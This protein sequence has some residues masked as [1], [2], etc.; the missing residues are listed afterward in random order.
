MSNNIISQQMSIQNIQMGQ[1][2]PVSNK[3]DSSIHMAM[4]GP[5][6]TDASSQQ[7]PVSSH[8][9]QPYG[10]MPSDH[11][12]QKLSVSNLQTGQMGQHSYNLVGGMET[13]FNTVGQQSSVLSKRKVPMDSSMDSHGLQKLVSNKRVA[14]AENRPWLHQSS[15][16]ATSNASSSP[17]PQT[18][19]TSN[20][21]GS[22][23]P[24]AQVKRSGSTK[25]GPQH[26]SG[27]K[28]QSG[29]PSPKYQNESSESVRSKLRESL[30]AALALVCEEQDKSSNVD[31]QSQNTGTQGNSQTSGPATGSV[32]NH[33]SEGNN[34]SLPNKG[35]GTSTEDRSGQ[36]SRIDGE[37]RQSIF[38]SLD[39]S[40]SVS[41]GLFI[42]DELLQGNGLSWVLESNMLDEKWEAQTVEKQP[43]MED[44]CIVGG[45]QYTQPPE[46]LASKIEAELYKLYGGVNKKYKEKGRSLL[47]NLK[48]R[49]NPELREKVMSGDIAPD[50]LC[51]M[52][53]E[54]LASKEL[55]E[56]R[57][58][59][60][61]E[62]A[63]M[64]VLPDSGD[65]RRLVKKTHKGEFQVEVEPEDNISAEVAI[66]ASSLT[67][68]RPKPKEKDDSSASRPD[69]KKNRGEKS[70]SENQNVIM[71]PSSD[72]SDFMQGLMV[73]ELK[74]AEFLPPIVSL[75]EFMESLNAEDPFENLPVD[76]EK[77]TNVSAKDDSRVG[78]EAKSPDDATPGKPG[79]LD[80]VSEKVESDGKSAGELVKS[81]TAPSVSVTK[82]ELVWE[83]LLQL[84]I[85][86]SASVMA[87]FK[88][89]EKAFAKAWPGLVEIKGRV[90]L[91]A[92]EKFL[93]ELPMSR[94]RAVM[95][96]Q[97]VCKEGSAESERAS[98]KEVAD[99]YI[100]DE[101]VGF[102][103]PAS[104]VEL[105][106]CPPYSKTREM[107]AKVLPKDQLDALN[108]I[109]NGLIGVIVWRK[110]HLTSTISPKHNS[111]KQNST[112]RR[113]QEKDANV[114]VN[115]TS[116]HHADGPYSFSKP[117][118][119]EDDGD[120][121]PPGFGPPGGAAQD[122]DDLP[123]FNF[124]SGPVTPR[125]QLVKKSGIQSHGIPS[126]SSH[127]Q[128][129]LRPVDQMRELVHKYGQPET[130]NT[131]RGV[132][133]KSWNDDD[134]DMPEWN[135]EDTKP[136]QPLHQ[137]QLQAQGV[138][139]RNNSIIQQQ[140]MLRPHVMQQTQYPH[141]P[142]QAQTLSVQPQ[143]NVMPQA[144]WQQQQQ[145]G[146]WMRDAPT[147]RGY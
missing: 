11:V 99:S 134:D 107:L 83:G 147:S 118:P 95:A 1:L 51:A 61:E 143:V 65:M 3:L 113:N 85:S 14:H 87:L 6:S 4:M 43:G 31:K 24:Q 55:S 133:L 28:N 69:K 19:S 136:P 52:T 108:S 58:A 8:Q 39:E 86:S 45:G 64:V 112:S 130:N 89:G 120:D 139:M 96:V 81:E 47:F 73:D 129:L 122:E 9:S 56:W 116:K 123:E 60:A 101:R 82:G 128:S 105:Y 114:D 110:P 102:A 132:V 94:S 16:Q 36:G 26:L 77:A 145:Q 92:F 66:G 93:Q 91:D 20:A 12:L 126:H 22:P 78:S 79:T 50:R 34:K 72:A 100:V 5:N 67:R 35:G 146:Q 106:V 46:V 7:I 48:D 97:F 18:Q 44:S 54:E 90:R 80:L 75:D 53:A 17:R 32:F 84:N 2:E 88:S 21:S 38:S 59:K 49:S 40:V 13:M 141:M 71:I 15:S 131:A 103:E 140:P 10:Y 74:D 142:A 37:D 98:L 138:F 111:K 119:D 115:V 25:A 33:A 42:K 121:V 127:S 76:A 137:P 109:D 68:M 63:Q 27:Q 124:S 30:G 62:L 29:Q 23:H 117:Q 125:P 104:G 70:S 41:D 135:P 144:P 57:M